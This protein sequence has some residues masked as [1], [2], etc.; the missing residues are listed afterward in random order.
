MISTILILC[1]KY[2]SNFII[3]NDLKFKIRGYNY[4]KFTKSSS[5]SLSSSSSLS[6]FSSSSSSSRSPLL[7]SLSNRI[8]RNIYISCIV[9]YMNSSVT[10]FYYLVYVADASRRWPR[11]VD[12]SA[13][14]LRTLTKVSTKDSAAPFCFFGGG[15]ALLFDLPRATRPAASSP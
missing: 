13:A 12:L 6:L 2:S 5:D 10:Q 8:E 4:L 7:R 11:V 9:D 3:C 15:W 14:V 1:W